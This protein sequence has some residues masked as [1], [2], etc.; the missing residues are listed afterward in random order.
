M[1]WCCGIW[2]RRLKRSSAGRSVVHRL[3]VRDDPA[4]GGAAGRRADRCRSWRTRAGRRAR[5]V[6]MR[7]ATACRRWTSPRRTPPACRATAIWNSTAAPAGAILNNSTAALADLEAWRVAAGQPQSRG[8]G[9]GQGD[10]QRGDGEAAGRGWPG[11]LEVFG[12]AAELVVANPNGITCD[13][14]GFINTPR[15]TLSTGVPEF[16]SD[17]SLSG[18]SVSGGDVTIGSKRGGSFGRAGLRRR[19]AADPRRGA[20]R[21]CRETGTLELVAGRNRYA[22]AGGA[23]TPLGPDGSGAGRR[24]RQLGARRH[25]CGQDQADLDRDRLRREHAG[26]D[27]LECGP[28]GR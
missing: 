13:G 5:R 17:G 24:D 14:C 23:V 25:V 21:R 22:Y 9:A 27:G 28:D 1:A 8:D 18:L 11:R 6:S 4:R 19:L 2:A 26:P 12:R 16:G 3:G 15:V 20:A 7:R 10:P